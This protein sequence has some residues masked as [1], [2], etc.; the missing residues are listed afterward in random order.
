MHRGTYN[1]KGR[2]P[3]LRLKG[4]PYQIGYGHG[5]AAQ[6]KIRHNL[7]TYFRRFKNETQLSRDEALARAGKY[8]RVI[9]LASPAYA[10]AME[11]VAMGA[12]TRLLEIA[13]LNVRYE[14]MYSQFARIGLKP[15]RRSGGCTAFGALPETTVNRHI[16]LAQNWDWIPQVEGLFLKIQPTKGPNVLCFTEAGVVGGKIGLNSEGIGLAINGLVSSK[17]DW[18]R[19][20]KPFHVI[21]WEILGSK[22]LQEALTR[23]TRGERSCSANFMVGQQRAL[24]SSKLVDVESAP[25]STLTIPPQKGVLTHTNHFLN[26]GKLGV[27]QILDE[28]RR[29][30][31]HRHKRINELVK[32]VR[33]GDEKLSFNTAEKMLKDHDGRPESVCR[34]ENSA[35]SKDERYQT[36]VSVIM[37]L[38]ARQLKA[39]IGS[40][41]LTNHQTLRL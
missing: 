7:E 23:I 8:L 25:S 10:R 4:S 35:F 37:D 31:L 15:H 28:E 41:C 5:K 14:L 40:P 2:L 9:R 29:S 24:S 6:D 22:S 1:T 12:N 32:P 33:D 13:A 21:C 38:Y 34:H 26:A 27:K 11:G 20:R 3:V 17:D 36:V 30:T 16:L 39:T 18:G 19:L